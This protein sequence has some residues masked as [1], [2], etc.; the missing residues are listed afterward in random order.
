MDTSVEKLRKKYANIKNEWRKIDNRIKSG[1]GLAPEDEPDWYKLV[2]PFFTESNAELNLTESAGDLSDFSFSESSDEEV[3]MSS[4]SE[5]SDEVQAQV[6]EVDFLMEARNTI[7]VT[8]KS[9]KNKKLVV[10]PHKKRKTVRSNQQALS[11]LASSVERIAES[12]I[13]QFK[14]A[15]QTD[16]KRDEMF[17]KFKAEENEKNRQHELRL[18]EIYARG[19]AGASSSQLQQLSYQQPQQVPELSTMS[20]DNFLGFLHN[21][22]S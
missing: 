10:A 6:G 22:Q 18:A 21:N 20:I 4:S 16:L 8:K 11:H 15:E 14:A 3:A 2:N 7:K 17:F 12:Q 1:S 13:K 19:M 9:T 5:E